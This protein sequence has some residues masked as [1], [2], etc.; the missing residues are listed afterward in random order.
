MSLS[1][2]STV[3]VLMPVALHRLLFRRRAM[4]ELVSW[5]DRMLRTGL[6]VTGL[7]IVGVIALVFSVALGLIGALIGAVVAVIA[8][9]GLWLVLPTHL[10]R[11]LP[12][13]H[14]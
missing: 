2:L 14:A 3:L 12:P 7:A 8:V 6:L 1:T 5:G 9:G 10:R 11:R 4:R 13:P